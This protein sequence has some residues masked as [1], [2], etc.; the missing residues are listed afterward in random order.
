MAYPK[1]S[2]RHARCDFFKWNFDTYPY[3]TN[4]RVITTKHEHEDLLWYTQSNY[5][6]IVSLT[7]NPIK[8][9]GVTNFQVAK[10]NMTNS[11]MVFHYLTAPST[12][13]FPF[14]SV[15]IPDAA[16][17]ICTNMFFNTHPTTYISLCKYLKYLDI[18]KYPMK[19]LQVDR[20]IMEISI[21]CSLTFPWKHA[22]PIVFCCW[23][24][25][26]LPRPPAS[27]A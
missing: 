18:I 4:G 5:Y 8:P 24:P 10:T 2:I 27:K 3:Q 23:T 15:I 19:Y 11:P 21:T 1:S 6:N 26:W 13:T 16:P 22:I 20:N 7:K 14:L 12:R 17:Y 9:I 25:T